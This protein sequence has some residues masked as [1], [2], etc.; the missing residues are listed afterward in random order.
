[1]FIDYSYYKNEYGGNLTEEEFNKYAFKSCSYISANTM[2]RVDDYKITLLPEKLISQIKKC[3]CELTEYF[4]K[5]SK[6][7]DNSLKV[8]SGES[9]GN[10]RSEQAGQV[11]VSYGDNSSF[12][13]DC[14][15]PNYRDLLLKS[16]L[17]TYLYPME[18]NGKVWNLTSKIINSNRCS[19]CNII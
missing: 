15:N 9:K 17:N 14:L 13:K 1:M 19:C 16:V 12:T 11:S 10:I 3:A 5:F 4:D 8:A 18:I 7:I 6:I 2:A